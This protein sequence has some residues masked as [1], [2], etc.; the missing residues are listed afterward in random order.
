ME[1][2]TKVAPY[3]H[4]SSSNALVTVES[5][6]ALFKK[7]SVP[8]YVSYDFY[9]MYQLESDFSKAAYFKAVSTMISPPDIKKNGRLVSVE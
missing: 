8:Y 1:F 4:L 5:Q 7:C 6:L 9:H 3:L 2:E